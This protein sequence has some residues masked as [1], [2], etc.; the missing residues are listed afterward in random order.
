M[1][2]A[3]YDVG[4][5]GRQVKTICEYTFKVNRLYFTSALMKFCLKIYVPAK[6]VRFYDVPISVQRNQP[7]SRNTVVRNQY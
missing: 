5:C 2:D 1:L 3:S 6:S 4:V 7:D